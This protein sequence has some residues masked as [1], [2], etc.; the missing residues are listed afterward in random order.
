MS[1]EPNRNVYVGHR[2]VPKIIG[3]WDNQNDYEG[4]SIVTH[5]GAS[6]TSKKRV[7]VGIDILNEEFWVLTGNYNVQVENYRDDVETLK[8]DYKT[9]LNELKTDVNSHFNGFKQDVNSNVNQF[10]QDVN[11][12]FNDLNNNFNDLKLKTSGVINLK[13]S[14]WG[15][16]ADGITDDTEALE[17]VFNY[18]KNN[19]GTIYLPYGTIKIT[20]PIEIKF[21]TDDENEKIYSFNIIGLG[22]GGN[23]VRYEN[24]SRIKAYNIPHGRSALEFVGRNNGESMSMLIE[25]FEIDLDPDSCS[26]LAFCLTVGDAWLYTVRRMKLTGANSVILR[27]GS[28]EDAHSFANISCKFDQVHFNTPRY[29]DWN[30]VVNHKARYGFSVAFEKIF[31]ENGYFPYMSDNITFDTCVFRG[32][33]MSYITNSVYNNCMFYKESRP[34]IKIAD[35]ERFNTQFFDIEEFD[36]SVG[37]WLAG[38]R[39]NLIAPYFE[40]NLSGIFMRS[41]SGF[42][43]QLYAENP[44]FISTTSIRETP[45]GNPLNFKYAIKSERPTGATSIINIRGGSFRDTA[46]YTEGAIINNGSHV[47]DIEYMGSLKEDDITDNYSSQKNI[48]L[49]DNSKPNNM[50]LTFKGDVGT[51]SLM[52]LA[53]T[54]INE[55]ELKKD[56]ILTKAELIVPKIFEENHG[57]NIKVD[58]DNYLALN[59]MG[60]SYSDYDYIERIQGS[61][62]E[63]Y[64]IEDI[65]F[66]DM[67]GGH[68]SLRRFSFKNGDVISIQPKLEVSPS[69]DNVEGILKLY[70]EG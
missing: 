37:L 34:V 47:L 36:F 9:D 66:K 20:R 40:G 29:Y 27:N 42:Y 18:A 39:A 19:G 54:D 67:R 38:G 5:Q 17:N 32:T 25:E 31:R 15:V 52:S 53:D 57:F 45:S 43:T 50:V 64:V 23:S 4:L 13:E 51:S 7:P 33:V 8:T 60:T 14:Q 22:G 49:K 48:K 46:D 41:L 35:D 24:G 26:E 62:S 10:K 65:P 70:F 68:S 3:E 2:Y 63:I 55:Y 30:G 44:A 69:P 58:G 1:K 11:S 12:D 21:Y 16:K 61:N 59:D 28:H 6:Y 56:Y